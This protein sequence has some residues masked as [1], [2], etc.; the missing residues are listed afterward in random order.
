MSRW[1]TTVAALAVLS[2]PAAAQSPASRPAG[3]RSAPD[4]SSEPLGAF[5]VEEAPEWTA[6]WDRDE[7]WT[8]ADGIYSIPLNGY[9]QP[10]QSGGGRT[11]F[12]FSDTFIGDVAPSGQRL[13]GSTL[14]NNTAAL[15][16]GLAPNPARTRFFSRTDGQQNPRALIVPDTPSAQPDHWYW[17]LDGLA[18]GGSAQIFA[19]RMK[20]GTGGPFNFAVDGV[21]LIS[22]EISRPVGRPDQTETPLFLPENAE[23][24]E[25][26]FGGAVLANT[27]SAGAP[28]A[29]GYVYVYGTQ[30][31]P[32][33]KRLVA[34]RVPEAAFT[35]FGQWEY[36]DGTAWSGDVADA[37]PLTGRISSEFSVTPLSGGQYL[38]VFQKDTIGNEVAVKLG[39]SP[40][41]PWGSLTTVYSCPEPS[42]DP[43]VFVY[44]AKAHPH[45]SD[46]GE[47]L[48]SYN[49]N[50]F[51]FADH[52]ADADI[53]RPRFIRL[54]FD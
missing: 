11:L 53:Y 50:T 12:L 39:Q 44:N 18:V 25:I 17:F 43:D 22:A 34:A 9:D 4:P 46:P 20:P 26:I 3:A 35:D 23:R 10:T 47:L 45:L 48:I 37:A 13:P 28:D 36:Y 30:N 51:E 7:G 29:D 42:L 2:A 41:G 40:V 1:T 21:A 14:V 6:L 38:L 54:V 5:H 32:L 19:T 52:F 8:G 31:D 33:V 24:G 16:G 15:L 49:V 27:A